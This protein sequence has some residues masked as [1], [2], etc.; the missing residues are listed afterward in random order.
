MV[1]G[2]LDRAAKLL[3]DKPE[4]CQFQLIRSGDGTGPYATEETLQSLLS[5][6]DPQLKLAGPGEPPVVLMH[7]ITPGAEQAC[8][9]RQARGGVWG[10]AYMLVL[11]LLG[12]PW[13]PLGFP[14]VSFGSGTWYRNVSR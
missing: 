8:I 10:G 5:A 1:K 14:L 4:L 13:V 11:V 9:S 6:L 2:E 7:R 12:V 3:A